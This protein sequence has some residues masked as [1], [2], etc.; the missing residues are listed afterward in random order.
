GRCIGAPA[1][2]NGKVYVF[3]TR[4]LY[5]FGRKGGSRLSALGSRLGKGGPAFSGPRAESREPRAG[6]KRPGPTVALQIV[7][8]E[9]LLHP[10][11]KVRPT[12]RG[13]DANG[14]VT[15]TYSPDRVQWAKYIPPT[16]RVRAEM[17]AQ[18]NAQGELVAGQPSAGAFQA[19]VDGFTGTFRGRILPSLPM[20][21]NFEGLQLTVPHPTEPG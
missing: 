18:F 11:E 5:C 1:A 17:D 4:K 7:P 3:S 8:S 13:I 15:S 9:V 20:S 6:A 14:F 10:G 21:E 12:V 19:T 2:W 16:A